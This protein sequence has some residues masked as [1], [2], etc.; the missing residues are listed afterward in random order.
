MPCGAI[1]GGRA[2]GPIK[3]LAGFQHCVH[4]DSEFARHGDRCPLEAGLFPELQSQVRSV[5]SARVLVRIT[6]A[7]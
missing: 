5:L 4:D 1:S 2:S 3:R 7:A 6:T